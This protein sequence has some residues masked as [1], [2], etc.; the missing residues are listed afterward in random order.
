MKAIARC[1][2]LGAGVTGVL[3]ATAAYAAGDWVNDWFAQSTQ[4]AP[5]H[6]SSQERG[7]YTAGGFN[8]RYRLTNDHLVSAQPPSIRVGCGG[9]DLVGGSMS[10][11]NANYLVQKLETILQAAPAF[12]FNLAMQEYCK[13]CE[14]TLQY[15]EHVTDELNSLQ[16]NDCQA[17]QG[18]AHAIVNPSTIGPQLQGLASQTTSMMNG[19][20]DSWEGFESSVKSNNGSS[21][22]PVSNAVSGCPADFNTVF[23]NG[24]VIENATTLVGL[25]PYAALMRGLVGDVTVTF[26]A[27]T[28]N[29]SINSVAPCAGNNG[30]TGDDFLNGNI[31][32]Q[33]TS[34]T[35]SSGSV[36][37]TLTTVD[38]NMQALA[39]AITSGGTLTASQQQFVSQSPLPM[40]LIMRDA[41]M[42]GRSDDIIALLDEALAT[43]YTFRVLSDFYVMVD[44]TLARA[45]Q[46]ATQTTANPGGSPNSCNT[47]FLLPAFDQLN[48]IKERAAKYR[49][50]A[51][52][53]FA[54]SEQEALANIELAS[55]FYAQHQQ[56][57]NRTGTSMDKGKAQ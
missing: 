54:N 55:Q 26:K 27:A 56:M 28:N 33:N 40:Y 29:Y 23:T 12:A 53:A 3:A 43:G 45:Q 30:V 48:Q 9:I 50:L 8:A 22:S 31:L 25:Q 51:E 38:T 36:S 1:S 15:M 32:V 19:I 21:P 57:Q 5:G 52:E 6:F 20:E 14:A 35:C 49:G 37:S 10:Y 17:S 47:T 11:L 34:G 4:T 46:L 39:S 41:S 18:L 16:L 13:P 42:A 44:Q 24:S 7:Y 2:L